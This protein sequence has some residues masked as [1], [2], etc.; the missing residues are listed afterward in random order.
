[1]TSPTT[2]TTTSGAPLPFV[3]LPQTELLTVNDRDVPWLEDSLG[4]GIK[5]K[6]LRLDMEAG[7]WVILVAFAPGSS[8]PLHYHTGEAEVFT[9]SGRWNYAEYPDQ[10]QTAGS[11]LFE[12]AGSVH[13]LLVPADNTEDTLMIVRVRGANVN[14]N[15]DGTLHSILDTT[16]LVFLTDMFAAQAG[17]EGMA[18]VRGGEAGMT[19][20][21]A[22][23]GA[24]EL[25][26]QI[27]E[28]L[29]R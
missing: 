13:T 12:P 19:T 20:A 10:P 22:E 6:P 8:V 7:V 25:P 1:M 28:A 24:A 26:P 27:A 2:T 21:G 16:A 14:F 29:D 15:E 3:A 18:Y 17:I 4:P 11:Y 23:G 9:L 5:V